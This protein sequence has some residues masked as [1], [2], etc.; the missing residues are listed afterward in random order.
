M[1]TLPDLVRMDADRSK[2]ALLFTFSMLAIAYDFSRPLSP[3]MARL[4]VYFVT[5]PFY[6]YLSHQILFQV[7]RDIFYC[8]P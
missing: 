5:V 3:M 4:L 8:F 1:Q 6:A 2:L 7:S